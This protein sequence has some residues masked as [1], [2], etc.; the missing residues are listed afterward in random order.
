MCSI[1]HLYDVVN[2]CKRCR[3]NTLNIQI[4]DLINN[5]SCFL[6]FVRCYLF[7]NHNCGLP[8]VLN[9]SLG[10]FCSLTCGVE[11]FPLHDCCKIWFIQCL[12]FWWNFLGKNVLF[13]QS[14]SNLA[15]DP[16]PRYACF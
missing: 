14:V 8:P 11:Q 5:Q 7:V 2:K 6:S 15:C 12:C 10:P 3:Q 16:H 9:S 4:Q 1:W 13:H